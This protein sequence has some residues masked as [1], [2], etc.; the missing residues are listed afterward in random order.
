[1]K[2]IQ[3]DL[4][5][6]LSA[7]LKSKGSA[8][9]ESDVLASFEPPKEEKFGDLST[10]IILR[11][12]KELK[13]APRSLGEEAAKILLP[14]TQE[15]IST[16]TVDGPGFLNFTFSEKRIQSVLL[17][18]HQAGVQFG[19]PGLRRAAGHA[20]DGHAQDSADAGPQIHQAR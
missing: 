7:F 2:S 20:R 13:T 3:Q 5:G 9:S 1:M 15:Q 12:A 19:P 8:L 4:S 10:S 18:I 14:K 6:A 11:A 17:E 16:I